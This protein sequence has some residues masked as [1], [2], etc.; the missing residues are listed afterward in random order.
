MEVLKMGD[1][2]NKNDSQWS[3]GLILRGQLLERDLK[4]SIC[5]KLKRGLENVF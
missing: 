4:E 5:F 3:R 2:T 1:I